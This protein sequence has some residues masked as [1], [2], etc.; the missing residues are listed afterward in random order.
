MEIHYDLQGLRFEWDSEKARL[1]LEK[2]GVEFFDAAEVFLDPLAAHG[3]A[4]GQS[5][6]RAFILGETFRLRLLL[7]VHTE[8]SERLRIISARSATRHERRFYE[9]G[10]QNG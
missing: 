5:E 1:N 2:H 6:D 7:V 8:R 9:E 3:D 4:D 10:N